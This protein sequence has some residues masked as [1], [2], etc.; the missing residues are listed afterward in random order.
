M[1]LL[2][3]GVIAET[4]EELIVRHWV[5]I[6]PV[7]AIGKPGERWRRQPIGAARY[8]LEDQSR[9]DFVSDLAQKCGTI[10]LSIGESAG[11]MWEID[12][13]L[14]EK[15]MMKTIF[16]IPPSYTRIASCYRV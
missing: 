5:K 13:V 1:R 16:V 3:P 11:V 15:H 6:G 12:M 9:Q 8:Y 10:I 7:L 14:S 2:D 4:L